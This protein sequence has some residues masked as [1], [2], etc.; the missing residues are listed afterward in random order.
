MLTQTAKE[1]LNLQSDGETMIDQP[2]I[3]TA[4]PQPFKLV[5]RDGHISLDDQRMLLIHG[6]T[7]GN[8][9]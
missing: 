6:P 1:T 9:G 5:F 4:P 8:D 7:Q 3:S 2:A